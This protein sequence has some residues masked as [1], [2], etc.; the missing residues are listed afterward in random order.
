[1][2]KKIEK[3]LQQSNYIEREYS[4][5]ALEDAKESWKFAYE[6]KDKIDLDYILKIHRLLMKR[7]RPDIAGKLRNCDVWI[8]GKKKKFHGK[9]VIESELKD[10]LTTISIPRLIPD[11]EEEFA[12]H[13]HV[14]FENI[15]PFE[16]GNGR[17][18]RI[19]WQVHRLKLKLST[20]KVIHEGK[21]Q[22][23]YYEWFRLNGKPFP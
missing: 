13:W 9:E 7:L 5:E 18:G 12:K 4:K 10:V 8:G 3:F 19:L 2:D 1:M 15:H 14:I 16:D 22:M 20:I 17:V 23:E 6:N 21:E 11:K